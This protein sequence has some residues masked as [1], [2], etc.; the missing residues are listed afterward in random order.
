MFM[1]SAAREKIELEPIGAESTPVR[2]TEAHS[3][4]PRLAAAPAAPAA[5]RDLTLMAGRARRAFFDLDGATGA[6][7]AASASAPAQ[8]VGVFREKRSGLVRIV[9]REIALR[10]KTGV[11]QRKKDAILRK[12]GLKLRRPNPYIPEQLVAFAPAG[13]VWGT[14]LVEAS[15]DLAGMDEVVFAA[16]NFVSEYHRRKAPAVRP[17]QW[18]LSNTGSAPG[19][20][21]GEDVKARDAWKG[22]VGRASVVVAILDDGVDID[23]PNLKSRIWKNPKKTEKDRFGRDFFVPTDHPDHFNPRPK[24]FH[25]PYDQMEGNDIHGTACAGVVAAAGS[26]GGAVGIAPGC[27]ILAV[28]IFHADELA[29]DERVAD[30]IRYAALHADVLSCSWTGSHSPD[31]ELALEDAARLGRGGRGAPVFCAAGNHRPPQP[32]GFPA[33][34]PRA[35][36]VGASTDQ[37]RLADYSDFGPEIAFVAPSSG[38]VQGIFTTDVSYPNRGFNVGNAGAGGAD[39]L[40]TNSFG[41]TSSATP[42]AAGI[43]ALVLSADPKLDTAGVRE[44]L[45]STCDKIGTGYDAQG[46]SD[47]FGRGRV[48]AA[49]AVEA[50]MK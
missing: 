20:S 27:R 37:A 43:A 41:G 15:A 22:T 6:V 46:R 10:F 25:F 16:P 38:G 11:D 44:V 17:E 13:G 45:A 19:Q 23:H 49:R 12:H 2:A 7:R 3:R 18:H 32:V 48:N 21:A 33:R 14:R 34:H 39:G 47:R 24:L 31:I 26:K 8:G 40:H 50:A 35:I 4:G 29:A 42:L 9:Y 5:H 28:K 30:A 36:A 1:L